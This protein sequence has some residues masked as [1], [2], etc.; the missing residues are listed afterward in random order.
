[1]TYDI[2]RFEATLPDPE[3]VRAAAGDLK[4][5]AEKIHAVATES[6]ASWSKLR[7]GVYKAPGDEVVFHAFVPV[8]NAAGELRS[9]VAT[10][11]T[12][13][14]A[15]ADAVTTLKTK[16]EDIKAQAA[17]FQARVDGRSREDWDDDEDLVK[18]EQNII[19]GLDGL[20][21]E[22]TAA[23]RDCANAINATYGGPT[24]VLT[25]QEGPQAG[26]I[27]YGYTRE[28][29]D[30]AASEGNIPWGRPTQWD[31]PWYRDTWDAVASFGK[32][33]WSGITG[34]VSGLWNMVNV[35]DM[36]TFKATWTGLGKLALD[37][38]IV[39]TPLAQVALRA[40]GHGDV[41]DNAGK[42]LLAVGKAAIHWDDWKRDPAYAAGATTF[43]LA[44]IL[45]TA[46]G[47]AALKAG[48][49]AGKVAEIGNA[50]GKVAEVLT[51][52]KVTQLA[53]YSGKIIDL[54]QS[55]KINTINVVTTS[56]TDAGKV[57]IGRIG[58][59]P[60]RMDHLLGEAGA[61]IFPEQAL[62]G[63][64]RVSQ[65]DHLAPARP[66]LQRFE[67]D[68][69]SRP[70]PSAPTPEQVHESGRGGPLAD[71]AADPRTAGA[72]RNPADVEHQRIDPNF[73]HPDTGHGT[74]FH[75]VDGKPESFDVIK[76][77]IKHET[78]GL[79]RADGPQNSVPEGHA[80]HP[81]EGNLDP[82]LEKI[83]D[84]DQPKYGVDEHGQPLTEQ[85]Y[86]N[87][88]VNPS[89]GSGKLEWDH[90]PDNAG[91]VDGSIR[92]YGT[93]GDLLTD[94]PDLQ[95]DRIGAN[96]GT[97]FSPEGTPWH[98]RS[99]PVNTLGKE[100]HRF[101]LRELPENWHVEVS[102]I[103]PA[104]GRPGGGTQI[105]FL[106]EDGQPVRADKLLGSVLDEPARPE[107]HGA[108]AT[109]RAARTAS[110][111]ARSVCGRRHL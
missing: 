48:S 69:P 15:Y 35:G 88:F 93:L 78:Y 36:D 61:R 62:A 99:L 18:D 75:D 108:G 64:P 67:A 51:A 26:E 63:G 16:L 3:A 49:V 33:V 109:A 85:E 76:D 47:G 20:Y 53:G 13:V 107:P 100:L 25:T 98:M 28:Q 23:Q 24:Y 12:A 110:R 39:T 54:G 82:S 21:A 91:A 1:M 5:T 111:R 46:G 66:Q 80:V 27:A 84:P 55:L 79:H 104:F 89:T 72:P 38:A 22:L 43:D 81:G 2:A 74:A 50:G 87:R 94:F 73:R 34:T 10:V 4:A 92:H 7:A 8:V 71:P 97:Y 86:T 37:V 96:T 90:Y 95:L 83:V 11:D 41:A 70:G 42:D 31:K 6:A 14:H 9:G 52:T 77:P 68:V 58:Q 30:S 60:A 56:I 65:L 17:S 32:G 105:R 19:G 59:L 44:T 40:T 29:L 57:V 106:D 102:E 103:A 101:D 45:L